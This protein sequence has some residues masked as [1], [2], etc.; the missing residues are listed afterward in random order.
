MRKSD[1]LRLKMTPELRSLL[2]CAA[3]LD[4]CTVNEF[5]VT[6]LTRTAQTVVQNGNVIHLSKAAQEAFARALIDP[7]PPNEALVRAVMRERQMF[8]KPK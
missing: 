6:A 8:R 3:A 2:E 7:P 4:G 5:A 1:Q